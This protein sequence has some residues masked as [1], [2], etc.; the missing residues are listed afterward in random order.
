MAIS[1][2]VNTGNASG[3]ATEFKGH[4][5]EIIRNI[6][7]AWLSSSGSDAGKSLLVLKHL[8][9]LLQNIDLDL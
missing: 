9:L 7:E 4:V 8:Q 1:R 2:W 3:T 5:T 6:V